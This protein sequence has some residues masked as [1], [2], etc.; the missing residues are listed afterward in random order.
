MNHSAQKIDIII[1]IYNAVDYVERCVK[2][3]QK[4]VPTQNINK[5]HLYNDASSKESL[6]KLESL[7]DDC[8]KLHSSIINEG[9]GRT[10]NKAM[11]LTTTDLVLVLN[12]DTEAVDNFLAP[13][14]NAMKEPQLIAV[15]PT[16]K[17]SKKYNSYKQ[18]NN[19]VISYLL[20]GYAFL[21]RKECFLAIGGFDKDF[22]RGYFED[23]ALARTLCT[24]QCFTGVVPTS[25]LPHHGSKSFHEAEVSSLMKRNRSIFHKKYPLASRRVLIY[26]DTSAFSQ[27][28]PLLQA[29]CDDICRNG[30]RVILSTNNIETDLPN[31]RFIQLK[32]GILRLISYLIRYIIRGDKRPN[33]KITEI[34]AI[35]SSG[36]ITKSIFT[37]L[38]HKYNLILK[39]L[40]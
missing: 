35:N 7:Q 13:L 24:S 22:G 20:S 2:S 32:Q 1:P 37:L 9:F 27:L 6:E 29:E 10:V 4:Y 23:D 17:T 31:Y 12:S 5:I 33:V 14:L 34:W 28:S 25:I 30:G 11:A 3:I 15:N 36:R 39:N 19:Y 26:L 16:T 8:I 18:H 38:A 40:N 21:I